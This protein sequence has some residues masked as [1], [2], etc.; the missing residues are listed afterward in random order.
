MVNNAVNSE[1]GRRVIIPVDGSNNSLRAFNWYVKYI[2]RKN[3]FVYF[4]HVL[5][6]KAL[7]RNMVVTVEN[8]QDLAHTFR[9]FSLDFNS[10]SAI[11][12]TYQKLAEAAGVTDYTT[13]ILGDSSIGNAILKLA[14]DRQANLIILGSRGSNAFRRTLLSDC[15]RY[16]LAHSTLPVLVVPQAR[17]RNPS[18]ISS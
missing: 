2:Y 5:Q 17:T 1:L 10:A 12:T 7:H 8:P 6:P 15:S 14:A 11:T 3:D 4:V 18:S 16:L 9:D 13:E